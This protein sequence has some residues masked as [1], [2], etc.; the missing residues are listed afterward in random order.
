MVTGNPVLLA[1]IGVDQT[2]GLL[3]GFD[4]GPREFTAIAR[5]DVTAWRL[6]RDRYMRM[7]VELPEV[8]ADQLEVVAAR[9]RLTLLMCV[10]RSDD[11]TCR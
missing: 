1:L 5:N 10:G 3:S 7:L 4:R 2:L 9:F 8:G 11:L 6:P